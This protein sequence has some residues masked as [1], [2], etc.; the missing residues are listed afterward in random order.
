[1]APQHPPQTWRDLV[2]SIM[3]DPQEKQ[4]LSATLGVRPLTLERWVARKTDPHPNNIRQLLLALP[5]YRDPLLKLIEAEFP[6]VG[7]Q[8]DDGPREISASFY[9]HVLRDVVLTPEPRFWSISSTIFQQA[10]FQLDPERLGLSLCVALCMP[11]RPN[12]KIQS[13]RVCFGQGTPPWRTD[14]SEQFL[15][16]GRES[17]AGLAVS[18]GHRVVIPDIRANHTWSSYEQDHA[19][20]AAAFPLV[21]AGHIAGCLLAYSAFPDSFSPARLEL[22]EGYAHLETLALVPQDFFD[23]KVIDLQSMPLPAHQQPVLNTFHLR[24]ATLLREIAQREQ[25]LSKHQAEMSVWQAIE[26]SF[27]TGKTAI[28]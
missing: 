1:M 8:S 11:P 25:V 21:R 3:E 28:F 7:L 24:V 4:R 10:L 18:A 13:L 6:G 27:L 19:Q 20:G 22:L 14:F 9:A 5:R 16:F 12:G 23:P 2:G 15:F 26:D 17:I